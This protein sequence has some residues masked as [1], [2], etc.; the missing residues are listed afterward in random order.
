[1]IRKVRNY[2]EEFK[3]YAVNKIE[4][5]LTHCLALKITLAYSSHVV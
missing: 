3:D 2:R 1:M 4:K 5:V